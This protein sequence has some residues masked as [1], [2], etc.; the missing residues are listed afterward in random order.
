MKSDSFEIKI[1]IFVF[2]GIILLT[3][4]TFSIGDF[5][6]KSG[7]NIKVVLSFADGVQEAAPVRLAGVEVGEVKRTAIFKDPDTGRT[8]VEL[9]L[10]LT[11][12]AKVEKDAVVLINTLGL[13]GEKYVE[14]VPG[15]PNSPL[16]EDG[17]IIYG[18]DSISMQNMTQKGYEVVLKLEEMLDSIN[19]VLERVRSK[20]GTVGKLLMEDKIYKDIEEITQDVKETVKD[21][22]RQSG[23]GAALNARAG[24]LLSKKNFRISAKITGLSPRRYFPASF[25][26]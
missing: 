2:V 12:D 13:I 16:L 26:K 4:V 15:T 5:L 3:I 10:W 9:L 1:G 7:Y 18:Q 17:G 24:I 19:V 21:I 23:W 14:I 20:E 25:R 11:Q 22:K 8:K 6:F